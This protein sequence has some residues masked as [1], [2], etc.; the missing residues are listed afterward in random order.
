[1]P[2]TELVYSTTVEF[3]KTKWTD[4][5][6]CIIAPAHSIA[7]CK[8]LHRPGLSAPLQPRFGFLW[9]LV[10]PKA[11]IAVESEEICECNGHTGHKLSQQRLIAEWLAPWESDSSRMR[12]KVSSDWLPSYVKASQSFSR[13]SNWM[14]IFSGQASCSKQLK[15]SNSGN[16]TQPQ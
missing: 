8:T 16:T 6:I 7:L 5:Q 2:L 1:M 13:Y 11:K 9:I 14:D 4:H 3:T 12:G 15:I 10:F